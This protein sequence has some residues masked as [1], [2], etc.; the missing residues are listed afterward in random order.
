MDTP[1]K[2]DE[3][4]FERI[5][6]KEA[7]GH[8]SRRKIPAPTLEDF[9]KVCEVARGRMGKIAEAFGVS[10]DT[11]YRWR[12]QEEGFEQALNRPREIAMD[13][14]TEVAELIAVGIPELDENGKFV[15][16]KEYPNVTTLHKLMDT[17]GKMRGFGGNPR[18]L[19][20]T[21]K[22]GS[23]PVSKWL[24]LNTEIAQMGD[25]DDDES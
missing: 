4:A 19:N 6:Q 14:L 1:R 5:K 12:D 16:W 18:D 17:Y 2:I 24:N 25:S 11:V 7:K 22:D 20:I 8:H 3:E 21:I 10:I 23:V 13:K 9:E 15:G